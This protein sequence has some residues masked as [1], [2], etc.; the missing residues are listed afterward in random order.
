MKIVETM[1]SR[2]A[3]VLERL[4]VRLRGSPTFPTLIGEFEIH[5]DSCETC[6]QTTPINWRFCHRGAALYQALIRAKEGRA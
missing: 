1:R 3:D 6:M 2:A 4:A 5:L